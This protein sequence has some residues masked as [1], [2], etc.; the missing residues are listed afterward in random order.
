MNGKR[1]SIQ[2]CN[3]HFSVAHSQ[4]RYGYS[5]RI[6]DVVVGDGENQFNVFGITQ[7]LKALQFISVVVRLFPE[8][9]VSVG[10]CIH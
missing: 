1:F 5:I 10:E 7:A 2:I 8:C 9:A 6:S 3:V 4:Q